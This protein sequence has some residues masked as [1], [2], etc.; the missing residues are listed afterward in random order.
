VHV[1]RGVSSCRLLVS[2]SFHSVE[3]QVAHRQRARYEHNFIQTLHSQSLRGVCGLRVSLH[4]ERGPNKFVQN[5][6]VSAEGMVSAFAHDWAAFEH[7]ICCTWWFVWFEV[8]SEC[9]NKVHRYSMEG[10]CDTWVIEGI[11]TWRGVSRSDSVC[12]SSSSAIVKQVKVKYKHTHNVW[13]TCEIS[14]V[15]LSN[16][17]FLSVHEV[18]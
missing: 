12:T 15:E 1:V 8:K 13:F 11:M 18:K 9:L 10:V 16:S 7:Q 2:L 4:Y 5:T 3:K 17:V 14:T 6:Q